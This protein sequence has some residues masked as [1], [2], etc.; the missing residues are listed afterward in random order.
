MNRAALN[1][2]LAM[3]LL[4]SIVTLVAGASW[5][6]FRCQFLRKALAAKGVV[7]DFRESSS[8]DNGGYHTYYHAVINFTD[9]EGKSHQ[10]FQKQG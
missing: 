9:K 8:R 3:F 10:F 4:L 6:Y 2:A 7:A 1:I 5:H